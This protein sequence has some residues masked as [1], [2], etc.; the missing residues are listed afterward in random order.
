MSSN[1]A[2]VQD[3]GFHVFIKMTLSKIFTNTN[4]RSSIEN[5]CECVDIIY[6]T[7]INI[8]YIYKSHSFDLHTQCNLQQ[9]HQY[10]QKI[11]PLS[12]AH[13]TVTVQKNIYYWT[14]I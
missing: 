8:N 13:A 12:Y 4:N 7:L 5:V 9:M 10:L 2:R 11:F 3:F 1:L 14:F 6:L